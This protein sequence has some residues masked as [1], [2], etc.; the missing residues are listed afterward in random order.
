VKH[1]KVSSRESGRDGWRIKCSCGRT[2][3]CWRWLCEE[4]FNEHEALNLA[5]EEEENYQNTGQDA[6]GLR[7]TE[8]PNGE[9]KDEYYA[10]VYGD[11]SYIV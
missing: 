8:F 7:T 4:Q 1:K 6:F 9:F 2:W 11:L 5:T 3:K 10:R